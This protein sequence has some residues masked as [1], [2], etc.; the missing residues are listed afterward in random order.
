MARNGPSRS[1]G[2]DGDRPGQDLLDLLSELLAVERDGRRLYAGYLRDA[3][4]HMQQKLLD[5]AELSRQHVL[6]LET[7]VRDL[8]GDPDYV[9]PGAA[10]AHSL[11]EAVL[12]ATEDAPV[13]RWVYRLLHLVSYELRDGMVW[14]VLDAAGKRQ[15]GHVAEVL[16]R[17]ALAV[18]S[19]EAL[20]AHQSDRNRERVEWAL[21]CMR[22]EL[23]EET[24]VPLGREY[25]WHRPPVRRLA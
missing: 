21:R 17:A 12:S 19:D 14:E 7:A 22:R 16:R 4:D 24:G 25:W 20:G 15:T 10:V 9:S 13:R 6:I 2:A 5:Y 1:E 8:G 18:L 3:P 23:S 11:T